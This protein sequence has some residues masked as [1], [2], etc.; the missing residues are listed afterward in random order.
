MYVTDMIKGC[1]PHSLCLALVVLSGRH[2]LKQRKPTPELL[3]SNTQVPEQA[4]SRNS[5]A[6]QLKD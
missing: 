5:R 2:L 6:D 3:L 4:M 1:S